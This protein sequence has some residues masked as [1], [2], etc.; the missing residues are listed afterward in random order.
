MALA[1]WAAEGGVSFP[2]GSTLRDRPGQARSLRGSHERRAHPLTPKTAPSRVL[3]RDPARARVRVF[4]GRGLSPELVGSAQP[5]VL[6]SSPAQELGHILTSHEAGLE[7]HTQPMA[8]WGRLTRGS[9]PGQPG[10]QHRAAQPRGLRDGHQ[11]P[12]CG[13]WW[14]G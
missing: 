9:C 3:G 8:L 11:P 13:G 12:S 6:S 1:T 4:W 5:A 7:S 2:L 10:C 14:S